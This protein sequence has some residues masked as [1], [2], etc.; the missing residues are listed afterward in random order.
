MGKQKRDRESMKQD[1]ILAGLADLLELPAGAAPSEVLTALA[2]QLGC[3][4]APDGKI[5]VAD[6]SDGDADEGDDDEDVAP[7][8]EV[9]PLPTPAQ[10]YQPTLTLLGTLIA[11][12]PRAVLRSPRHRHPCY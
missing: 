2:E 4:V 6:A 5:T 12:G 1:N 7:E 3:S 11:A 9:Q 8:E 10:P